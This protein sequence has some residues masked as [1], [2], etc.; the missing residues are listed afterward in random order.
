MNKQKWKWEFNKLLYD[1]SKIRY[2]S[3]FYIYLN[4]SVQIHDVPSSKSMLYIQLL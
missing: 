1:D 2:G 4:I 3:E